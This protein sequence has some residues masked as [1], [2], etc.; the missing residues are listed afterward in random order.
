LFSET[1]LGPLRLLN[2]AA[3]GF[4]LYWICK[5]ISWDETNVHAFR[6]LAFVGRKSLPVFAWSILMTYALIAL[7]PPTLNHTLGAIIVVV[8]TASL[9]IPA[10][11]RDMIARRPLKLRRSRA[12]NV[13]EGAQLDQ[14]DHQQRPDRDGGHGENTNTAWSGRV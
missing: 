9:T 2:F 4:V 6:W 10:Q 8:A 3:F 12:G 1:E 7:L 13:Y 11:L 5:K 14:A